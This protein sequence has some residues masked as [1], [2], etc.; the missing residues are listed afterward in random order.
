LARVPQSCAAT[1]PARMKGKSMSI[2]VVVRL[3]G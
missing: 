2:S 1:V 3:W